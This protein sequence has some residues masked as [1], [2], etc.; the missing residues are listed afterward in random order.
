MNFLL[1]RNVLIILQNSI[2][3]G[4]VLIEDGTIAGVYLPGKN[5]E[6]G[7]EV[8]DGNGAYLAPVFIDI[9][10]HGRLGVNVMDSAAALEKVA[11]GQLAHGVTGFLAG[12]STRHWDEVLA[13][14]RVMADYC[15]REKAFPDRSRCLGIYSEGTFFSYEKRGAH[16]PDWLFPPRKEHVDA[17]LEA[18]NG[19]LKVVALSPE[20]PAALAAVAQLKRRGLVVAAA[21]S[22]ADYGQAMTGIHAGISLSTHTFNGMR[23]LLHQDPG[24]L[25]A[26]LNDDRVF[27]EL[28][29]DGIHVAP[30]VL[31]IVYKLKGPGR[32]V[33]V[34]DSVELN[35]L[36]DGAYRAGDGAVTLRQ[37][38]I[39]LA[40]GR[41]AGS[42]LS[43]YRAV[44]NMTVMADVTLW[45]A[46]AMASLVPARILGMEAKKGSIETGKDADLVLL[47]ENLAVRNVFI[48]GKPCPPDG[49][50]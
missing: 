36:P 24:I 48:A 27:C 47:D 8:F 50:I 33:L 41:L 23:S 4:E 3:D 14:V 44:R 21:H 35:G 37:G 39:R 46:V 20:L 42:C 49:H 19:A 43:L 40:D 5:P 32:T 25:G 28:I 30:A 1:I 29:A 11:R 18:G 12:T 2:L 26:V 6:P 13:A 7:R 16:N 15:R 17:L 10:N 9:H 34:S 45:D 38:A 22:N 31:S